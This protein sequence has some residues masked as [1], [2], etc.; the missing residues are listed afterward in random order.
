M[1]AADPHGPL[2]AEGERA[3]EVIPARRLLFR[4]LY[5]GWF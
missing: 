2:D 4:S 5:F 1:G 3:A